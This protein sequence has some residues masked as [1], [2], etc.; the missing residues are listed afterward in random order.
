MSRLCRMPGSLL[1]LI[2][3]LFWSTSSLVVKVIEVDA[4]LLAAFRGLLSGIILLPLFRPAKL[5]RNWRLLATGFLSAAISICSFLAHRFT[6]AANATALYYSAPLWV[7]LL[8]LR[9]QKNKAKTAL[10]L[11]LIVAGIF[12]ILMEPNSGS[13]RLGNCLAVMAGMCNAVFS[14]SLGET[15]LSQRM[16]YV[17]F[18][19]W[20]AGV[21]ISLFVVLTQPQSLAAVPTYS[22]FTW[23]MMIVMAL[24][25]C[26][27]PYFFYCAALQKVSVQRASL[28]SVLE[29]I[30]AP[31]WTF[32]FLHE[33]PTKYGAAGWILIL[34]GILLSEMICLLLRTKRSEAELPS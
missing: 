5:N 17:A 21:L 1:V 18:W 12:V 2:A 6:T 7:F 32:L 27:V 20:S 9:T 15:E 4:V 10:P 29:F 14:I 23:I 8:T 30:I 26:V 33:F 3:A 34:I 24:T 16:N 13:N 25:Q 28:L 11:V 22:L 31:V 19:G